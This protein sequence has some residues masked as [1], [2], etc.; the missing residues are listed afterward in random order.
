MKYLIKLFTILVLLSSCGQPITHEEETRLQNSIIS[1]NKLETDARDNLSKANRYLDEKYQESRKLDETISDKKK[2]LNIL[3]KG[4]KPKYILKLHFQ[5][6]KME[7]SLDRISFDFEVPVDE[8]FYKESQIGEKLGK[9]S[10]SFKLF[11]SADVK[12]I[13]KRIE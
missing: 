1:L 9:G 2:E 6:H 3:E 11:H 10:R 4:R 13:G 12:V 8:E 5:E 7:L